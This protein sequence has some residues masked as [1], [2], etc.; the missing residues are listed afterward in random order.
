[1]GGG[2]SADAV[3]RTL[4]GDLGSPLRFFAEIGSTNTEALEWAKKG[5]PNGALVVTNHQ[6]Q[7]RGRW[8]R[9][10]SSAPGK[11]LQFSLILRPRLL[12]GQLGLVTTALGVAC[13]EAIEALC[14]V[15]PTIKWPNDVR[16]DRRKVAGILVETE[17]SGSSVEV[18][19]AGMGINVGWSA[20]EVPE[21][22]RDTTTSLHIATGGNPPDRVELL[23]AVLEAFERRYRDLPGNAA[24]LVHDAS[25]RSD[26]LGREVTVALATDETVS[27]RAVGLSALGE[28]ELETG[29][30]LRVLSVGEIAR[31][32]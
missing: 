22:L 2:L 30:D 6:T 21:E 26:V 15:Q 13:A 17:L 28:L 9:L 8:G 20:E 1:M 31:L 29:A 10:W 11:L 23:R 7:G 12:P 3:E 24:V 5:A 19:V 18:V 4:R 32:R 14:R 27:G 25:A 16:I